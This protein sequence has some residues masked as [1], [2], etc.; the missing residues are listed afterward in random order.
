MQYSLIE[1]LIGDYGASP[2]V[3]YLA[4]FAAAYASHSFYPDPLNPLRAAIADY[5]RDCGFIPGLT[6]LPNAFTAEAI[7]AL[8]AEH[9]S[10][11]AFLTGLAHGLAATGGSNNE[12]ADA[13]AYAH[14]LAEQYDRST[15]KPV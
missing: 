15:P 5:Q 1:Q 13:F 9:T 7:A 3:S 12:L 14:Q 10:G 4:A 8:S 6:D 2:A 11:Q